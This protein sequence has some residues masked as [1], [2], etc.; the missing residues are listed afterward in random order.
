MLRRT[1]Q[2]AFIADRRIYLDRTGRAVEADDPARAELL[3]ATGG[4]LPYER[5]AELGLV[6]REEM[7]PGLSE[8]DGVSVDHPLYRKVFS[9]GGTAAVRPP[10]PSAKTDGGSDEAEPE[11]TRKEERP[12]Q[13]ETGVIEKNNPKNAG[14]L[15]PEEKM[16]RGTKARRSHDA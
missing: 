5:A 16:N 4:S 13:Q 14:A 9:G 1:F 11:A 8:E 6:S 10:E 2:R 3:V 12:E 15:H 7:E